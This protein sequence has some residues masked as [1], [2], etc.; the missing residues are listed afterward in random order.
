MSPIVKGKKREIDFSSYNYARKKTKLRPQADPLNHYRQLVVEPLLPY[1]SGGGRQTVAFELEVPSAEFWQIADP[2]LFMNLRY[3]FRVKAAAGAAPNDYENLSSSARLVPV[4]V[5][6]VVKNVKVNLN[7]ASLPFSYPNDAALAKLNSIG[8]RTTPKDKGSIIDEFIYLPNEVNDKTDN[9]KLQTEKLAK[10]LTWVNYQ[11]NGSDH[12][13]PLYVW[14][15]KFM[16]AY[17]R[18]VDDDLLQVSRLLPE[19][20]KLRVTMEIADEQEL[21]DHVLNLRKATDGDV[22]ISVTISK[23]YLRVKRYHYYNSENTL[24]SK[25]RNFCKN[26]I[27]SIPYISFSESVHNIPV[28]TSTTRINFSANSYQSKMLLVF[29]NNPSDNTKTRATNNAINH[30]QFFL[31]DELAEMVIK[32]GDEE[33]LATAVYDIQGNT[34]TLPKLGFHETQVEYHRDRVGPH[35]FWSKNWANKFF[36]VDLTKNI[37]DYA[38]KDQVLPEVVFHF[39]W[40]GD[41]GSPD[42]TQ[43]I[44]YTLNLQNIDVDMT[45]MESGLGAALVD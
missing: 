19:K 41:T 35:E 16:P 39:R 13:V 5:H 44:I 9:D 18:M 3:T 28:G 42:K 43:L 30:G 33:I 24:I 29:F 12:P 20:S 11:T 38:V 22:E 34:A 17:S 15:F 7:G 4:D 45:G 37:S 14:P 8:L 10:K 25:Y 40:L 36:V 21:A 32:I 1:R 23:I 2:G 6:T 27:L 31:P 26:N